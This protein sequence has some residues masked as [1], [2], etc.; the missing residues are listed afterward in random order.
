MRHGRYGD[1]CRIA[2]QPCFDRLHGVDYAPGVVG[3]VDFEPG[4]VSVSPDHAALWGFRSGERGTHTSRTIMFQ[5]LSLLLE[6][7]PAEASRDDYAHLVIDDNC[8][9]KRT[10]ATRKLSL[11]RL[12]ELYG[13]NRQILLFRVLRDM[14][15]NHG[16]SRPLLALLL[17]VARDPLLRATASVVIR[18][19]YGLEV[20]RQSVTDVVSKAAA[21]R[22]DRQ[23]TDKVVRNALSSW[24]QSGHLR[25][26][27][28]KI[29]Q[30][31]HATPAA[32]A[33]ALLL[34]YGTGRRGRL[35]FETPWCAV[36]DAGAEEL[37]EPAVAARR[38]GLLDL[39][40]SGPMIDVSFATMLADT[41]RGSINGAHR[42]AG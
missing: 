22:L 16:S 12:R 18:S 4:I 26:S 10:T 24:T 37:M 7:A 8:L 31:V 14:W 39:K 30:R 33:Y 29:R 9:G 35:L 25:G 20:P 15:E 23:T 38:L 34:G 19:P 27:S 32:A 28:S 2:R 42:Q 40:Q 5:E 41:G 11:Q 21:D 13:L 6:A 17:A 3:D 36:L 1:L